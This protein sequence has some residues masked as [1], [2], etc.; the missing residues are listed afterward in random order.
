MKW[1]GLFGDDPALENGKVGGVRSAL[2]RRNI[3]RETEIVYIYISTP[4]GGWW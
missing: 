4:L 1:T 3:G 2:Q